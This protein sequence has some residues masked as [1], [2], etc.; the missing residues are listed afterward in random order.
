MQKPVI[1]VHGGAGMWRTERKSAGLAGVSAAALAGFDIL[2][3]GGSAL[4]AVES[5]VVTMENNE[6]FNAGHGSA[7]TIDKRIEMEASIMDGKTLN[8]GA[9]GLLKNIKNPTR[10]ARIIM[11]TTDHIFII[12][13]GAEKLAELFKLEIANPFTE[14]RMRYWTETKEKLMRGE[15]DY[16]P[17]LHT[18]VTSNPQLFDLGTVGAVALDKDENVAAA[19][20]TGGFSLKFPGRIG[21]S[22]IIGCGTYADNEA[23]ASSTTGIGEIAVKLVL[24]K[25][26]CDSMRSGKTAQEA[27]ESSIKLVNRRMSGGSMGLITLDMAGRIGAA[28]NSQNLCWAY[29]TTKSRHPKTALAAR[30]VKETA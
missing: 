29:M 17:K 20:S 13:A 18:L 5:A 24:S 23:G 2:R 3:A 28:H 19:T 22:A 11:E 7:L 25:N 10:L 16:L 14:L 26:A 15:H 1:V 8:A 30:I 12:G 6:V 4:D 9:V 21:D 27:A